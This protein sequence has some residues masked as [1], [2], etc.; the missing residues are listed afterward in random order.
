M[1]IKKISYIITGLL[2][3]VYL[4]TPFFVTA[5]GTSALSVSTSN[6]MQGDTFTVTATA[7]E[8]GSMTVK[9]N[10]SVLSVVSC[11]APGFTQSNGE[12]NFTGTRGTITFKADNAGGS[13]VSVS[14]TNASASSL[15]VTVGA[16]N[17]A[18]SE[19]FTINGVKYTV[20]EKYSQEEIPQSFTETRFN[21]NGKNL[22][23]LT[24]GSMNLIYLKP[25]DNVTGL[26][27]FYIYDDAT[28]GVVDYFFLGKPDYYVI[29]S[30]P[31]ELINDAL[32]KGQ[33]T[34]EQQTVDVYTLQGID[35]FV[36]VYGTCSDGT[37]GWFEYDVK[38]NTVQRINEA[39]FNAL[40]ANDKLSDGKSLIDMI[41]S[42]NVR[43]LV[44]AAIFVAI[45]VIAIIINVILKKRDDKANLIDGDEDYIPDD[46]KKA[47][48]EKKKAKEERKLAKE[49]KKKEKA[50]AKSDEE[51]IESNTDL[52]KSDDSEALDDAILMTDYKSSISS[53]SESSDA[54]DE[55]WSEIRDEYEDF[56]IERISENTGKKTNRSTDDSSDELVTLDKVLDGNNQSDNKVSKN[57]FGDDEVLI[58]KETSNK[59]PKK[60]SSHPTRSGH[61][62]IID[63]NDL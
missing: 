38:L 44:A 34:Y 31:S 54:D 25:V 26:G 4:L 17:A 53:S 47:K 22:K 19:D 60:S 57:I 39:I 20:S 29:P 43:Y 63:L 42:V 33:I 40:P 30:A 51:K 18:A 13:A 32:R 8:S 3:S 62:G 59:K 50:K 61:T 56:D 23:G 21:I 15:V 46:K 27:K 24:N 48:E 7:T 16:S 37:T 52:D 5:A 28:H 2:M 11:D 35:D 45:I 49:E 10:S 36:Y 14:S 55:Y 58:N 41:K 6:P 9:Y 12:V 1:Y